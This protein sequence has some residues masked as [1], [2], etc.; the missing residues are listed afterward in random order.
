MCSIFQ[1]SM[2]MQGNVNV[3][4]CGVNSLCAIAGCVGLCDSCRPV[5][6]FAVETY[7][8]IS[9][10]ILLHARTQC[11]NVTLVIGHPGHDCQTHSRRL[12]LQ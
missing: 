7:R 1:P 4:M 3:T 9:S 11:P 2:C 6:T 5:E 12:I 8:N 10:N